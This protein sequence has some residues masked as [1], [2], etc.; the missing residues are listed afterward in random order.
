MWN[1][2]F[3]THQCVFLK[4]FYITYWKKALFTCWGR[5]GWR[6]GVGALKSLDCALRNHLDQIAFGG[7]E[8]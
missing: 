5:G 4:H 8:V 2:R 7:I 3:Y 1:D 6:G